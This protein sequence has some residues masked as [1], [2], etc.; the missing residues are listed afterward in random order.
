M[1]SA[2]PATTAPA[3]TCTEHPGFK[4]VGTCSRC[5]RFVC[6][7]CE[8]WG[9]FCAA[10]E[11]RRLRELPSLA[12]WARWAQWAL[13][14]GALGALAGVVLNGWLSFRF[15]GGVVASADASLYHRLA[16]WLDLPVVVA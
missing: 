7:R 8:T 15:N 2:A 1:S 4:P 6:A 12:R 9:E 16:P 13:S 14:L 3:V 10:C 5:G 11:Y